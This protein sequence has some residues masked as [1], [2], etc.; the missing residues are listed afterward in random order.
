MWCNIENR[1]LDVVLSI[2]IENIATLTE[3]CENRH[4]DVVLT[5]EQ[6]HWR[7]APKHTC[8]VRSVVKGDEVGLKAWALE[9]M[10]DESRAAFGPYEWESATLL[11][12]LGA[13]IAKS[14]NQ[15]DLH[16][17]YGAVVAPVFPVSI[18]HFR[19]YKVVSLYM[20]VLPYK[21]PYA[22]GCDLS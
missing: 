9:G 12:D 14:I 22:P 5:L 21:Y 17:V 10:S 15:Q 13:A 20:C 19:L 11:D 4:L 1:Q 16:I 18:P 8:V 3:S 2:N 7:P 6:P